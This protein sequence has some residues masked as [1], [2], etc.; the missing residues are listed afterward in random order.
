MPKLCNFPLP[1]NNISVHLLPC[2]LQQSLSSPHN[3]P[4]L[5]SLSIPTSPPSH[6]IVN[7]NPLALIVVTLSV[8]PS[9]PSFYDIYVPPTNQHH[10]CYYFLPRFAT[11]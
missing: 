2:W 5:K 7:T 3:S 10:R 1:Y 6:L 9:S 11:G 8:P 4:P